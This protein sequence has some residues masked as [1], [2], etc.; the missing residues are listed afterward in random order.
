LSPEAGKLG[1]LEAKNS[2]LASWLPG[3][4]ASR[5]P[6]FF[7]HF[8]C[9]RVDGAC[10]GDAAVG[11]DDDAE[12][13]VGVE[14]D[15]GV[16]QGVRA[17]VPDG[18]A[19]AV[20]PDDPAQCVRRVRPRRHVQASEGRGAKQAVRA[21]LAAQVLLAPAGEIADRHVHR[22]GGSEKGRVVRERGLDRDELGSSG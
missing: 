20:A 16:P 5:L 4:L 22:A 8:R 9:R 13:G 1:S 7:Q 12:V 3:F 19:I 11:R 17:V 21:P 14:R 10:G 15:D 18:S 6:G 2:Y